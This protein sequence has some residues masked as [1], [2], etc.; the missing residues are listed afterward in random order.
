M[1]EINLK[2]MPYSARGS[3]M[4]L[5]QLGENYRGLGNSAGYFLRTVHS[6]VM[7]PLVAQV[8]FGL[9]G[10]DSPDNTLLDHTALVLSRHDSRIECCYANADTLLFRGSVGTE[11][12]LDFLTDN[13]PYDYIYEIMEQGC[14]L[15]MANCFKN[16][17]KY[18]IRVQEGNCTLEQ[19]WEESSALYS[20]LRINGDGGFLFSLQE[21][22]TE[23]DRDLSL[24]DFNAARVRMDEDLLSVA[25]GMPSLPEPYS[26]TGRLAA[27]LDWSSMV[28]PAGFLKTESMFM[29][30]NWMTNVWSWDHCF[31]ALALAKGNPDLAWDNFMVMAPFQDASGRL[32]DS[33]SDTRIVWNYCKPPI[34]GWTFRKLTEK[35]SMTHE[36]LEAA[37]GFLSKWTGWWMKYRRINGLYYYNH[38]ND[39]GWDNS[40]AFSLLPPVATPE[41][42][43]DMIL[44]MRMLAKLAD[45]L[46][47]P[48]S[49]DLWNDEAD[50]HREL[51]LERCFRNGLPV[52]IQC[53]TGRIV[54]NESLLPYEVLILG[55]E[56]P[57]EIR[58][59][60]IRVLKSDRFMTPC[61]FAT[62]SP[63]SPV[64]RPDGYWRGPIWAPSTALLVD[65][66]ERCGE[67][68]LAALTAHKFADLCRANGFAENFDALTGEGQRDLAYTWTASVFLTLAAEYLL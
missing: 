32:P 57:Q 66:L 20:R 61:G 6:T 55:D 3:W 38:G 53:S 26:E 52:A 36:Q 50:K 14:R 30:K 41:L 23:W 46:G 43:A 34:H 65:G 25:S 49:R 68:E 48:E 47:A 22:E 1:T 18:L 42:Q 7:T 4:V 59:T 45:Q 8:T 10:E 39:S 9:A 44:Q 2:Q 62:E 19:Q 29:S 12:L 17:N 60:I 11:I 56:L 54:E 15:Y 21:I 58:S 35:M 64:Y 16:N 24:P 33:I 28:R 5:S 67:H 27:W 63:K 40:T 13:G 31:N 37:Y 51:F